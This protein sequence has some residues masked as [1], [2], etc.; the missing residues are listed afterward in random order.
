[1][2][3]RFL[4]SVI[5]GTILLK[6]TAGIAISGEC[7][8]TSPHRRAAAITSNNISL[9]NLALS[10][11]DFFNDRKRVPL[12][13]QELRA[14][15]YRSD[16]PPDPEHN[17]L[18]V[19]IF[20]VPGPHLLGYQAEVT[21]DWTVTL[22]PHVPDYPWLRMSS[23]GI[24][25]GPSLEELELA[26]MIDQRFRDL[27]DLVENKLIASR[28]GHPESLHDGAFRKAR[29][30]YFSARSAFIQQSVLY[31]DPSLEPEWIDSDG[32][33]KFPAGEQGPPQGYQIA[34]RGNRDRWAAVGWPVEYGPETNVTI[35]FESDGDIKIGDV[36]G[37]DDCSEVP[38]L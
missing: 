6:A 31:A 28:S 19:D 12:S 32:I 18:F 29:N 33:L 37:S 13:W 5:L 25:T 15:D 34:I 36:G 2:Q 3:I 20:F 4:R 22:S 14:Y 26:P 27:H 24:W 10:I 11:V 9:D 1:M 35:C 23:R 8:L 38:C 7:S 16:E 30:L 21:P 17:L